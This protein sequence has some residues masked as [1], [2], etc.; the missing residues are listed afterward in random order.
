MKRKISFVAEHM[1]SSEKNISL[2]LRSRWARWR[3]VIKWNCFKQTKCDWHL[4][5]TF[6]FSETLFHAR[7]SHVRFTCRSRC[8]AWKNKQEPEHC[9][10]SFGVCCAIENDTLITAW[11]SR[12]P[13]GCEVGEML[14]CLTCEPRR[15][16]GVQV[17]WAR[18][19]SR[20]VDM[21]SLWMIVGNPL[22]KHH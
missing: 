15:L 18:E 21:L 17:S 10:Y 2:C 5:T 20:V 22:E 4:L 7:P 3:W 13:I 19:H 11:N 9:V 8:G 1:R 14:I 12:S 16:D 6:N